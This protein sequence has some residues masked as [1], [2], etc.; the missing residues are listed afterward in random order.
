MMERKNFLIFIAVIF[1]AFLMGGCAGS[2]LKV[3]PIAKSEN[4]TE[5]VNQLEKEINNAR[6]GQLDVLAPTWFGRAE[7]SFKDAKK[8]L[9]AGDELSQ[10]LQKVADGRAQL[11]RAEETSQLVKTVLEGSIK[12]RERARAVGAAKLEGYGNAEGQFIELSKAIEENNLKYAQKNGPKVIKAFDELELLA[13]KDE[14]LGEARKLIRQAETQGAR[15]ITPKTLII[16][17]RKLNDTDAYIS[18]NRY[19]KEKINELSRETLFQARRLIQVMD[20]S[21]KIRAME[22]EQ[23]TLWFEGMLHKTSSKLSEPDMRDKDFGTQVENI[24]SSIGALQGDRQSIIAKSK[25][26]QEKMKGMEKEI[27]SLEGLTREEQA[28]KERLEREKKDTKESLAAERRFNKLFDEVRRQFGPT[29]AEVYKQGNSLVI[30]LRAIQFPV[31]KAIIMPANYSL[32]SKVQQAIRTFGEPDVVIEGHTDST[33]SDEINEKLSQQRAEAVRE[34]FVANGTLAYEKIFA[35]GYG[36]AR[37]LASNQTVEG[38]AINRRI[39]MIVTPKPL[40]EK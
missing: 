10:I 8:K 28:E 9:E 25:S 5:Q 22:P 38:R 31:G 27:T 1:I 16:A 11:R 14:A 2:E 37:P 7:A 24:L 21:K 23:I 39:D 32:L 40:S 3:E 15:K 4:P 29:E 36:S 20:G 6:S 12:A 30:R 13:I 18:G 19:Q 17:Q 26:Q 34:Y 33:G 35:V